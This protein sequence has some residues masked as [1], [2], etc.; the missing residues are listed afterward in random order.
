MNKN[1][2]VI[3]ALPSESQGLFEQAPVNL[4]YCGI[5]KVN[6]AHKTT[7]VILTQKPALILNLGSAGSK[8]FATHALV[9]C[10]SFVQRDM[11][12][13]PLGFKIG[14]TPMD[15]L[16]YELSVPTY[17]SELPKGVCGTGDSFEVGPG[18]MPY[19]LV[20]MEAYAMAK[21]CRRYGVPFISLK[22]ITD[23]AD[24]SAHQDWYEN[25]KPASQKLFSYYQIVSELVSQNKIS[26]I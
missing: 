10:E 14:E 21:I 2:S 4:H 11:D 19:H 17:F 9:E 24:D 26:G 25:L 15:E 6:A 13:S 18:K 16:G 1:I 7:E 22:Y 23:G 5:G 8:H 20:D 3:M 12:I